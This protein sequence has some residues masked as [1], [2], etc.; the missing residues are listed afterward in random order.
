MAYE[1]QKFDRPVHGRSDWYER[2]RLAGISD[3]MD[4]EPRPEVM[5]QFTSRLKKPRKE[6]ANGK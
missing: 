4:Q 2:E 3:E 6:P 5:A 1:H